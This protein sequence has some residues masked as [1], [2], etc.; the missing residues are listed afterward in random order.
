MMNLL[1]NPA[2]L[3]QR[4][5]VVEQS[6]GVHMHGLERQSALGHLTLVPGSAHSLQYGPLSACHTLHLQRIPVLS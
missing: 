5:P 6:L 1:Q 3:H 4:L 2:I